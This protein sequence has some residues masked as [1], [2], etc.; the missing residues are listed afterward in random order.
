MAKFEKAFVITMGHEG[1]Y[2]N[3]KVDRGG[4]TFRGI[5][6]RFFPSWVGWRIVDKLKADYRQLAADSELKDLVQDFYKSE[7]WDRFVGDQIEDQDIAN[8][9][10]DTAVNLGVHKAV[11]ILQYSVN[12]LN[13]N[14][15]LFSNVVEDGIYG[16]RSARALSVVCG[17][18]RD[19]QVL[20]KIMNVEQGHFY[21]EIMTRS[22]DQEVFARGWYGRVSFRKASV[23]TH[24][25]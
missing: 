2:S 21:N 6:R 24:N 16:G 23:Q 9:L 22:E 18:S 13:R 20:Y 5:S 3:L 11:K 14:Q 1:G 4:E 10:F 17:S 15:T 19:T 7:F 12:K 25:T 8:E